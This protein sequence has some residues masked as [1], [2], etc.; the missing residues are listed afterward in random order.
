M[1]IYEEQED[2][3]LICIKSDKSISDLVEESNAVKAELGLPVSDCLKD[4]D[5]SLANPVKVG[6]K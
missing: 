6:V 4:I 1:A 2:G 3:S 5:F